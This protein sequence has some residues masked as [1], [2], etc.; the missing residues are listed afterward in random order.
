[1]P[2]E[3][4]KALVRKGAAWSGDEHRIRVSAAKEAVLDAVATEA[5]SFAEGFKSGVVLQDPFDGA[6][7]ARG[8]TVL[9]QK[10]L[11]RLLRP[12]LQY[13]GVRKDDYAVKVSGDRFE[14]RIA[15]QVAEQ[16][17]PVLDA[18]KNALAVF[19]GFTAVGFAA[20]ATL[21]PALAG[22]S[23]GAGLLFGGWQLRRGVVSG[24]AM[25]A[26]RVAMALGM[27]AQ[28]EKLILPPAVEDR[29]VPG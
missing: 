11:V 10:E 14:L 20:Y 19:V 9:K 25:L 27:L 6:L 28:E 12:A 18:S 22:V 26:A 3:D 17:S 7:L 5:D 16:T 24:R 1:M 21:S 23:W 13:L 2:T 15:K 8:R 29:E 4:A